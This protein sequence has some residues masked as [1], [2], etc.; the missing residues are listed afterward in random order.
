VSPEGGREGGREARACCGRDGEMDILNAEIC[1]FGLYIYEFAPPPSPPW[2]L[3]SS[4][5]LQADSFHMLS[6]VMALGTAWWAQVGRE[7]GRKGGR[8]GGREG[9]RK[10]HALRFDERES[11]NS[12][13]RDE[14]KRASNIPSEIRS[15]PVTAL[16]TIYITLR[17]YW[18]KKAR[19]TRQPSGGVGPR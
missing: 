3:D 4:I 1:L 5:A 9:G 12:R 13:P 7:E 16:Y 2:P 10:E 14:H 18:R 8:E 11:H 6:D 15:P 17:R 19:T